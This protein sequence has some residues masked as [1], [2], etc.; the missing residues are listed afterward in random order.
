[1][2]ASFTPPNPILEFVHAN[3][4]RLYI[5]LSARGNHLAFEDAS[6]EPPYFSSLGRT[7]GE[8][9]DEV[10]EFLMSEEGHVTEIL[11]GNTV[12]GP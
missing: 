8:H 10:V 6:S 2:R 7:S 11:R 5:G 3:R 1:M 12:I 4:N 9:G